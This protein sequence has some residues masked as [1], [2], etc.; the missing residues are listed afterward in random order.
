MIVIVYPCNFPN[1]CFL[2]GT[3]I[4][5]EDEVRSGEPEDHISMA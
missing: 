5:V 2:L 1:G 4:T 3:V